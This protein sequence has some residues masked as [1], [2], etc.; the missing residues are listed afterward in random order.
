MKLCEHFAHSPLDL[1]CDVNF[2]VCS[3]HQKVSIPF[4]VLLV[5]I[6]MKLIRIVSTKLADTKLYE[7][8]RIENDVTIEIS[9][10]QDGVCARVR[11]YV[12]GCPIEIKPGILRA[13]LMYA[14]TI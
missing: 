4:C 12:H 2:C 1:H 10:L 13:A 14:H 9:A 7:I 3:R 11:G 5:S 6:T 8:D